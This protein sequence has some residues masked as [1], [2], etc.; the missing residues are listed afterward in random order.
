MSS[1][2]GVTPESLCD[3]DSGGTEP[4]SDDE[5]DRALDSSK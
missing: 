4:N 2:G 1:E 5:F 3:D